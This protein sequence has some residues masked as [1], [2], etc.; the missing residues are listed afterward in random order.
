MFPSSYS[1]GV[2]VQR[3]RPAPAAKSHAPPFGPALQAA[4]HAVWP[5]IITESISVLFRRSQEFAA[6]PSVQRSYYH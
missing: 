5:A 2:V 1:F 6:V 4:G 3:H